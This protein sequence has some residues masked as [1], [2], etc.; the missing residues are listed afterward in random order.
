M[1]HNNYNDFD[2]FN[3]RNHRKAE[4]D[5]P[6]WLSWLVIGLLMF[7]GAWF[8][9]LPW[10]F[11]KL[12]GSD[13][14][15]PDK[16]AP[17]LHAEAVRQTAQTTVAK[18]KAAAA[19]TAARTEKVK[20]T[21]FA[22]LSKTPDDGKLSR[23]LQMACG[24]FLGILGIAGVGAELDELTTAFSA[25]TLFGLMTF[26]AIMAGGVAMIVSSVKSKK[27]QSRYLRYMAVI[28][29]NKAYAVEEL[30]ARLGIPEKQVRKDLNKMVEKGFFGPSAYL[31]D[32]LG[33]LFLN[34]AADDE[35]RS[36]RQDAMEKA[37]VLRASDTEN[38][39]AS[40]LRQIRS[41]NDRIADKAMSERIDSIENITRQI[42]EAVQQDSQK[43]HKIDRFLNYYLPTTLKLLESYAQLERT[44]QGAG[45]NV[46]Q[47]MQSI[48]TAMGNIEDGFRN[49]LDSMYASDV[50]DIKSDIDVMQQ[51]MSSDGSTAK[52]D[53]ATGGSAAAAQQQDIKL[54]L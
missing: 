36:A 3:R 8:I 31:N 54:K 26:L 2:D 11:I 17:S 27:A 23:F 50:I 44:G 46:A 47:S 45:S 7:G 21:T 38:M 29:S 5:T 20:N 48:E 16:T 34:S 4:D 13:A 33:Y 28:G 9:G 14:K 6:E 19:T 39:Y 10:L 22:S 43:V 32:E 51:M 42:F 1:P 15:K 52:S 53:F 30:V 37:A 12:F 24:I 25:G 40:I 35:L 49:L 18:A 41:V